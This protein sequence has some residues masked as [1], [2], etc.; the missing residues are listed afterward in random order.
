M[1]SAQVYWLLAEAQNF[2]AVVEDT[3]DLSTIRGGSA[4]MRLGVRAV[5]SDLQRLNGLEIENATI[6]GSMG[7][8]R[9]KGTEPDARAALTAARRIL[10]SKE[11]R[12]AAF[13][14]ALTHGVPGEAF[15]SVRARLKAI[16]ARQRHSE[17]RTAYPE[18]ET[19][20]FVAI[21]PVDFVRPVPTEGTI[22]KHPDEDYAVSRSVSE[23]RDLGMQSKQDV[24]GQVTSFV[25]K[26]ESVAEVL[27]EADRKTRP[28]ALQI[29]SISEPKALAG[30][31]RSTLKDK[32]AVIHLDGNGFGKIQDAALAADDTLE[33]QRNFDL[34]LQAA[35]GSLIVAVLETVVDGGGIGAPTDEE[36]D[37]RKQ[38]S[39]A[40]VKE[41]VR[42]ETLLWGGD[43]IMFIVPARLGWRVAEKIAEVAEKL[44]IDVDAGK[45]GTPPY[46]LRFAVG[47]VFCHH[48]A[49]ISRIKSLAD[50]LAGIAKQTATGPDGGLI[51]GREATRFVPVVMESF[52][53]SGGDTDDL[54]RKRA[55]GGLPPE[56][57]GAFMTLSVAEL[58]ALRTAAEALRGSAEAPGPLSRGRL[59]LLARLVQN[60]GRFGTKDAAE[61]VAESMSIAETA[62][63]TDMLKSL[64]GAAWT[65]RFWR[66]LE[67]YWDYLLPLQS[68]AEIKAGTK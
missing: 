43:E 33:G 2:S 11:Y 47:M 50:D 32:I 45:G 5:D 13:C 12:H 4:A 8:W 49:P 51:R 35:L 40:A 18:V 21:C 28:F 57:A 58:S 42:F 38:L 46:R 56:S 9:L 63:V 7:I 23:R 19:S 37:V 16:A 34:Q 66:L 3:Q 20:P 62:G 67:E 59:R 52:D 61:V 24:I 41:I 15:T 54:M 10:R 6:G 55:P 53:H 60:G 22:Q 17:A 25:E 39:M 68:E 36:Q 64:D 30:T 29:A 26:P 27:S 65:G 44:T 14:V 31:L 48:D 1:G